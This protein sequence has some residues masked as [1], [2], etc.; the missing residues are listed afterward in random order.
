[1]LPRLIA[2]GGPLKGKTFP[3]DAKEISIG[4]D[5]TNPLAIND[6]SA[7]RRHCLIRLEAGRYQLTDLDSLNG[8]FV[9]DVPT[10]ERVLEDGD[11]LR[12]GNSHFVFLERE[13]EGQPSLSAILFDD[14]NAP[15]N[16]TIQ[17]RMDEAFRLIARDF[18]ALMK[19][20]RT[21]NAVRGLKALARQLLEL[22]FE[23]VPAER[24][25]LLVVEDGQDEPTLSFVWHRREGDSPG[26]VPVSRTIVR[27]V[28]DEGV[29]MLTNE[30]LEGGEFSKV[31][32]VQTAGARSL[33]CVPLVLHERVIGVIYLA[34]GGGLDCFEEDHL[35]LVTA[36]ANVSA[37]ALENARHIDWLEDENRRLQAETNIGHNMVGEGPRMREVYRFIARAA[38][39][40]ST[41]LISG[42]SGTGKELAARAIHQNS[43]RR[44]RPFVAIN[45]AALTE[46]LLESEL[47]GHERGA[48]TGAIAQKRGKFEVGEGGTIFLDEVGEIAPSLQAR[49]LR[50]LQEREFER[51]G[52]TRQIKANIRLIAATNRN[53]EEEMRTGAFRQDLFYR[54]NV[55]SLAMPPLRERREDIPL[56]AS[57]F[58]AKHSQ[59]CSRTLR[60]IAPEARALLI[61][62]D[63]PGNV[64]EMENAIER[65]VV[66]GAS[67]LIRPEDLPETLHEAGPATSAASSR[68]H[69]RIKE[70]KKELIVEA[71]REAGGSY[72]EAARRLGVHP[73][74]LH[75]LVKN[76]QLRATTAGPA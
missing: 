10:K 11:R 59:R 50:V 16:P 30:L 33:L 55:L 36:V 38:P 1:M 68:Y 21:I 12:V 70:L 43:R 74:Y 54:L 29:A 42:E 51:V 44:D 72:T 58:I 76:L 37:A 61:N 71:L 35:H 5:A 40:D 8:T 49:L 46:T 14:E 75:R 65:A 52:G 39:T 31:R 34:S 22:I 66:L 20:S 69:D 45:C 25:A 17:L 26:A 23:V 64:R 19:I 28:A 24:G 48:F 62:Y 56:L 13:G 67:D 60:G 18:H 9:N 7:S 63:W 3:L 47:F 73:N 15:A 27:R 6:G 4:R 41:V 53:L 2:I 32:S 57:Y